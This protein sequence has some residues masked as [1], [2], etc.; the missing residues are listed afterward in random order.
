MLLNRR[1]Q[2]GPQGLEDL[3]M[4]IMAF[5]AA[6]ALM[7][8][9]LS[10]SLGQL[11]E[12]ALDDIHDTGKRLVETLSGEIFQTEVSR[13]YGSKVLDERRIKDIHESASN[14]TGIV[15]PIEYRFWAKIS[16]GLESW[17][18]GPRPPEAALSYGGPVTVLVSDRL[19]NG[20]VEV[21]IWRG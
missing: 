6:I 11:T 18:F 10:I 4:A 15:G 2:L 17:E 1:G 20:E 3:P 7:I 9:F 12:S 8:I 5:I 13:S 14:L 21:K 19:E 16:A